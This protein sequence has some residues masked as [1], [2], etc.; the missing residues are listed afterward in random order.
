MSTEVLIRKLDPT[1]LPGVAV[2]HMAAFPESALTMLGAEAV[3]RYYEWQLSGPHDSDS[4]GAFLGTEVVGFCVGGIFRGALSGYLRKHR[5][6]LAWRVLTHPW[7]ITNPIFRDRL[8]FVISIWKPSAKSPASIPPVHPKAIKSYGILS[9]GVH[10]KCQ[11]LGIGKLL[12]RTSEEVARRREFSA[13]DLSVH[14]D[15]QQAIKFYESLNWEKDFS[16]G[17]WSG[18]MKK[19]LKL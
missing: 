16:D 6:F 18:G 1:D 15:N 8:N 12:M 3:R 2:V 11:G 9:I 10:P 13:M 7:L 17:V 14:T 5:M 19:S 4:L